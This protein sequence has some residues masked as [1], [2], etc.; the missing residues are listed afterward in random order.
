MESS[1]YDKLSKKYSPELVLSSR[2]NLVTPLEMGKKY[3]L[4][5]SGSKSSCMFQVDGYI[6]KTGLKCDHLA[7]VSFSED[8]WAE[9]F[10][11]LKGTD[12]NHAIE[13]LRE[14]IKKDIFAHSSVK[15]KR[16]RIVASSFPSN[17]SNSM[18]EKA[19]IEFLKKY[20]C[21]LRGMKNGQK[22]R[23]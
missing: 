2:T 17:K 14:T 18:M 9:I 7:L 3:H 13:Q 4:V 23:I 21:E 5:I 10:I 20:R 8:N 22:D 1:I 19:K 6:I 12:T 16:A 15:Q 11:E